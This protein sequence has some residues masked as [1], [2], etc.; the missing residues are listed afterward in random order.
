[1][2]AGLGEGLSR[3][4]LLGRTMT[5]FWMEGREEEH[6]FCILL[7]KLAGDVLT[8]SLDRL[9]PEQRLRA[10]SMVIFCPHALQMCMEMATKEFDSGKIRCYCNRV[11]ELFFPLCTESV[12][13]PPVL[14]PPQ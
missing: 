8:V 7:V 13:S 11:C 4:Q 14:I 5:L 3:Q 12:P 1:M 6:A 9:S 2:I 10:I